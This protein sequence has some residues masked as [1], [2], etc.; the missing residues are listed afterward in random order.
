MT[1]IFKTSDGLMC[2][3]V[4]LGDEVELNSPVIIRAIRGFSQ[5]GKTKRYERT[6]EVLYGFPIYQEME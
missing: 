4:D 1:V 2:F 3:P 6:T 5:H